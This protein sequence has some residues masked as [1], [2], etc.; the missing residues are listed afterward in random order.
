MGIRPKE[1]RGYLMTDTLRQ[2]GRKRMYEIILL[3]ILYS[4]DIVVPRT[5]D[6]Q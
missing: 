6:S 4:R 1:A 5:G 3:F 2:E